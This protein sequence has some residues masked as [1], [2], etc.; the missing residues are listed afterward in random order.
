[1]FTGIVQVTAELVD[2]EKKTNFQRH[3][4]RLDSSMRQGLEVGASV[5]HNGCC[6]TVTHIDG[7]WVWF[8]LM[9]AT[10]ALTNLGALKVERG[11]TL[12]GQQNLVMKLAVTQCPGISCAQPRWLR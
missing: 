6:L 1:M 7:D 8:D 11:S 4:I 10:L 5:A 2:I 12:N 3:A 9:Q